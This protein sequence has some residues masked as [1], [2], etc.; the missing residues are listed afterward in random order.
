[1]RV[2]SDARLLRQA[3]DREGTELR[4]LV[5]DLP[6]FLKGQGVR[7]WLFGI[8]SS[9][10]RA[11]DMKNAFRE[12]DVRFLLMNFLISHRTRKA[13]NQSLLIPMVDTSPIPENG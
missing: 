9:G 6:G 8:F 13:H 2:G 11:D 10:P 12:M 5:A 3:L 7:L 4:V 1:M